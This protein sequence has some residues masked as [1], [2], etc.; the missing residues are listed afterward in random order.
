MESIICLGMD[1][2]KDMDMFKEQKGKM[3][4]R[5]ENKKI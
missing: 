2:G 3:G 5:V 4:E 1:V